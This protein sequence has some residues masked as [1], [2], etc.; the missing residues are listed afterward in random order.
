MFAASTESR[1]TE[2]KGA[3]KER[4]HLHVVSS[5]DATHCHSEQEVTLTELIR[6]PYLLH[7]LLPVVLFD[8]QPAEQLLL[9][10]ENFSLHQSSFITFNS[11]FDTHYTVWGCK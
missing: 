4:I 2:N 6:A 3:E 7:L 5:V 9:P 8:P 11:Q 10:A 1:Q